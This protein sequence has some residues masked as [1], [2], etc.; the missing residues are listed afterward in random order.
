MKRTI[1]TRR[2]SETTIDQMFTLREILEKTHEFNV[3]THTLFIDFKQANDIIRRDKLLS[4]MYALGISAKLVNICRLTLADHWL[5]ST[6]RN[7]NHS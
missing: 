1:S 4:A 2:E 5:K 6:V 3:D 7:Q